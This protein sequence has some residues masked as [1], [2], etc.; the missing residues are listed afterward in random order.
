MNPIRTSLQ[1]VV[2]PVGR[3]TCDSR[4]FVAH[5]RDHHDLL[6]VAAGENVVRV[7]PPLVIEDADLDGLVLVPVSVSVP[8]LVL[9][10]VWAYTRG[11]PYNLASAPQSTE[12]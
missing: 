7:L 12:Q 11:R 4:A 3:L 2:L 10:L 1:S 8:V 9:V 6:L 5:V